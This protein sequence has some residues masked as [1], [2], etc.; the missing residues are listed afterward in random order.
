MHRHGLKCMFGHARDEVEGRPGVVCLSEARTVEALGKI[1]RATGLPSFFGTTTI[2]EHHR[3]ARP[4]GDR[5][6]DA[7]VKIVVPLSSYLVKEV[8]RDC[9]WDGTAWGRCRAVGLGQGEADR[10]ISVAA[11][12]PL[13]KTVRP[14]CSKKLFLEAI[15]VLLYK[16]VRWRFRAEVGLVGCLRLHSTHTGGR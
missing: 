1:D 10:F 11:W 9:G 8:E 6:D 14:K 2:L 15:D 16:F 7:L 3:W 5:L 4:P 12:F 13:A